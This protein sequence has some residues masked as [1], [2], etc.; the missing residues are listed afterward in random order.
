MG[1]H[2]LINGKRLHMSVA[3]NSLRRPPFEGVRRFSSRVSHP[4]VVGTVT[5]QSCD[6][7]RVPSRPMVAHAASFDIGVLVSL[8]SVNRS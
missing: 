4:A 2:L 7:L 3:V 8:L 6:G 5:G 1:V